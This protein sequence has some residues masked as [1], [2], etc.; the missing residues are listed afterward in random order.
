MLI[1]LGLFYSEYKSK[2]ELL[3]HEEDD[4]V[5]FNNRDTW[6]FNRQKSVPLTGDEIITIPH[7][8]ILVK[9]LRRIMR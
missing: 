4:S 9:I 8:L 6:F 2:A 3:D 1:I 7:I 5:S